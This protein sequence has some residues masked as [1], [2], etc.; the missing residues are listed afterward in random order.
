MIV[1]MVLYGAIVFFR[2]KYRNMD[3]ED[4]SYVYHIKERYERFQEK[5]QYG[6]VQI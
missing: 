3:W 6:E 2:M 5:R 4:A 1:V